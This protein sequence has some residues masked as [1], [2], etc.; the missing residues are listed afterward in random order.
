MNGIRRDNA[1]FRL[2]L[3]SILT[4]WISAFCF[5]IDLYPGSP[6]GVDWGIVINPSILL[7]GGAFLTIP[8]GLFA[9]F[10]IWPFVLLVVQGVMRIE[11]T[12]PH[13]YNWLVWIGSGAILGPPAL[14]AYSFPL[15]LGH[16]LLANLILTG[17]ICGSLCAALVRGLIGPNI[18]D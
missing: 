17:V 1:Y 7:I 2:L 14:F 4:C 11:P 18:V 5:A 10:A 12:V 8:A 15:G 9:L 6:F 16:A 3:A 13:K